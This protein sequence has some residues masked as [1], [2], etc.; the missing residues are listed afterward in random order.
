[1]E[2]FDLTVIGS[3]PGGYVA[4]IRASQ[5]GMKTAIVERDRLGGICL[6]WGCIPTKA[7]LKIAEEYEVLKDAGRWGFKTGDVSVDWTRVIARSREAA[8][9][10]S[11]GVAGLMKKNKISVISGEAK[12]LTPN[13]IAVEGAD[14][15]TTEISTTRTIL[16]TGARA[17]ALPGVTFDGKRVISYKEAMILPQL[18][19]SM[20]VIGAGAIGLEFAYFFSVFGTAV[21]IVEYL[22][23]L[24]P[25]GDEDICTHLTRSFQKRGIK[26]HTSS[27]VKGVSASKDGTRTTFEKAGKEESADAE[28]TLVA[29]GVKAN[30]ENLGLEQIG[31]ALE[32][33][34]VKVDDYMRT[35]VGSV[36]AIGDVCGPPALA[37][38]ASAEGVLAVEHMAGR[39]PHP[40]D[41]SSIP[42]CV[43]CH[44][45]IGTVGLTEKEAREKGH[46]VKVGKFPFIAN[47]KS[48]AVGDGDGFVKIIGDAK[49]GEILGAHIIGSEATELISELALA[50]ATEMTV[51]DVHHAV[52]AHPTL[53]ESVMEAAADWEGQVIGI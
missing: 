9:K 50:K 39:E 37:H 3:G 15:K 13:R 24:F 46:D 43:Y 52:H 10:L 34:S 22:D 29:V 28:V 41:Y 21:T 33:G 40:L 49:Y 4:A 11:K 48:V 32:R 20:T 47:G 6:N 23:R 36:Y 17:S 19:R 44:P 2:S 35:S 42:A 38:V 30:V 25:P 45:Q 1:M 27:K 51:H 53:A 5:L 31:V 14:K 12:F 7:L 26:I 18:P 8:E 16:A